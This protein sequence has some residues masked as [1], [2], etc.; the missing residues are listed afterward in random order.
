MEYKTEI[1]EL[2]QQIDNDEFL[3]R[4]CISLREYVKEHQ[5]TS[6]NNKVTN[7]KQ[8]NIMR[9]YHIY[10]IISTLFKINDPTILAKISVVAQTHLEILK[11]KEKDT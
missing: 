7:S 9:K 8:Q 4:I 10:K 2:V 11:E 6:Q 5:Q 3:M 1:M